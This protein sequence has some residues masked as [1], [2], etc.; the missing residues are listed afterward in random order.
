MRAAVL[1][2]TGDET[3]DVR[4]LSTV[5]V[6]PGRVRLR[7][8]RAGL[9]HSDL[10]AMSGV[11]AHPAPFVPGH[12]GA[13]EIV[14][15]GE[16]VA[17]V[18]A[19]DRVLVCWMPPCNTCPACRAG[20]GHL[21][22]SGYANLTRPGFRDGDTPVPG[23]VGAGTFA[24]ETVVAANA[25]MPIPDDLPY[26]IAAL[27]GCG[28]TTGIGAA[29]NTAKVRPASSVVVVG[30]GGVG[31]S[32]VQGARV[33]GAAT[34][35]AVDPVPIRRA[36]AL[37]FGATDA[38]APEEL[39]DARKRLTGGYG[40]DYA[41]EAVGRPA[42]LRA[43]YDAARNG[44]TVCLVGVGAATEFPQVSMAELVANEKRI[45]PSFYGGAD[46]R[47]TV[48][49]V[50]TL[51]RSGRVDLASMITHRVALTGVNEAIRQMRTGEALRTVIDL[52]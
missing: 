13:G 3:L 33:A 34:I 47:R 52:A 28:V 1:H 51:W 14:E 9:C 8:H 10:S 23:L 29:L 25:A 4:E 48:P 32:I 17:H 18:K 46:V 22:R 16:G 42:T 26:D 49:D 45:V 19:G 6:G 44:G 5:P 21:C 12:E 37:R 7:V 11:L 27:I 40:F 35:L 2:A 39:K 30:L 31:V 24:E 36:L 15:V 41:F 50:I 43:A 38:V 20:D